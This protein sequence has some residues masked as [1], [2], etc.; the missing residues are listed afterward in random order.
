MHLYAIR[1]ETIGKGENLA[2][3]A[4]DSMKKQKL[5]FENNDVLALASK[6]VAYSQGRVVKLSD[7]KPSEESRKLAKQ[8][9]LQ[10]EFAELVL[11]ESDKILGG[12]GKAVLTIKDNIL[13]ANAGIDNKNS[14]S[15]FAVLWPT[16]PEKSASSIREQIMKATSKKTGVMIVD[17]GLIPL[18]IGTTGL[19]VAVAGFRPIRDTRGRADIF[20]KPLIITRHAVADDLASAAHLLMGEAAEKTPMVLIRDAPVDFDDGVYSSDDMMMPF[21]ECLFMNTLKLNAKN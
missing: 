17:S 1:T 21:Q 7:I 9:S 2:E 5:Q 13:T 3:K 12:V 15:G 18:R 11:R 8:H 14:P 10:A 4:L 19:A 20:G 6:I 16:D